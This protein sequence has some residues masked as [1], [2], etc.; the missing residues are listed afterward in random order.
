[1]PEVGDA[2]Y[3]VGYLRSVGLAMTGAMGS[4]PITST[5]LAA[6]QA[7]QGIDLTPFEFDAILQM[8]RAYLTSMQAGA[9]PDCP[10]PFGDPVNEFDRKTVSEKVSGAFKAFIQSKRNL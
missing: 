3:L 7:G 4:G 2:E 6:W 5:E 9:K 1:M 10:P 8:S